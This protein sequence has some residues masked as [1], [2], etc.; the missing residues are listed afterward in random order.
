MF[1]N[2]L[3]IPEPI[4]GYYSE[5]ED[6]TLVPPS[7]GECQDNVEKVLALHK[8][9]RVIDKHL[10]CA[11]NQRHCTFHAAYIDWLKSEPV[12]VERARNE[13]G[14]FISDDPETEEA[15]HYVNGITPKKY[16]ELLEAWK[17][18]E[19]TLPAEI[20]L[21][22]YPS[23]N[24]WLKLQGVEFEGTKYSATKEDMW[25]LS[26]LESY[27]RAGNSQVF[28]FDNGNKLTLTPDNIDAFQAV[29]LP[30]RVGFFK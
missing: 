27:V 16:M 23:Y 28:E 18:Q 22:R 20:T 5:Q 4:R 30:F 14:T 24:T 6:G 8:P 3:E 12:E 2:L 1:N 29:W 13:D 26:A 15:E 21:N 17:T 25:G 10:E 11:N 19:P 7:F 9:Q